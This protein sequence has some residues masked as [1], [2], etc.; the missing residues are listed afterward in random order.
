MQI[1]MMNI[2]DVHPYENNPR[3]NDDAVQY[4]ANSIKEFGF[5]VPIVVDK[6]GVIVCGHTRYKAAKKLQLSEVPCIRADDLTDEQIKAYRLAD[7]KVAERSEWDDPLLDTE[8]D[9]IVDFNMQDFD[10][11]PA[12]A[13]GQ[14]FISDLLNNDMASPS[15]SGATDFFTVTLTFPIAEKEKITEFIKESGKQP[16]VDAVTREVDK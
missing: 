16:L 6:E 3:R 15:G 1:E 14:D 4:V 7:N 9:G 5:K 2:R 13:G 10:F 8:L 12:D 11:L